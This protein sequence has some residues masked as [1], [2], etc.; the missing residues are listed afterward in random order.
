[1][2]TTGFLLAMAGA[3]VA[4]GCSS[5]GG[6][7]GG[8]GDGSGSVTGTIA[9]ETMTVKSAIS[10]VV[11][12][13]GGANAG[14]V[15]LVDASNACAIVTAGN[16]PPSIHYILIQLGDFAGGTLVPPA[17]AGPYT[18]WPNS[19]TPPAHLAVV[20]YAKT[21]AT[22]NQIV[23]VVGTAGTLDLTSVSGNAWAGSGSVATG[24]A[25]TYTVSFAPAYCPGLGPALTSPNPPNCQ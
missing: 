14:A 12:V 1:M 10:S 18:V 23:N 7:G 4:V 8:S 15:L 5:G 17:A 6:G 11:S 20:S 25:G 21:D 13:G 3:V 9:G 16:Q 24:T 22:C 19:G 2:K